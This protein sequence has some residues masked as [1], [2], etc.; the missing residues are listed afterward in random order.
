MTLLR[1]E[2]G[3]TSMTIKLEVEKKVIRTTHTRFI[4]EQSPGFLIL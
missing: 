2:K 3:L 4:V 1:D